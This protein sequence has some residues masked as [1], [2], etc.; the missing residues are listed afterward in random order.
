MRDCQTSSQPWRAWWDDEL[1]EANPD[2]VQT[3][4][5]PEAGREPDACR[6]QSHL[7]CPL[8]PEN[9]RESPI[10]RIAQWTASCIYWLTDCENTDGGPRYMM[11]NDGP[12]T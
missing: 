10:C 5:G 7:D 1:S 3:S 6:F 4:R 11:A 12:A 9:F 2:D 8:P